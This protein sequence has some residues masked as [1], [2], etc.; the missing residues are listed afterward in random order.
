MNKSKNLSII[1]RDLVVDGNILSTGRL[2]I[3]GT[4]KGEIKGETV[5]IAEEGAVYCDAKVM[6]ITIGGTF[7]GEIEA[8]EELVILATGYCAGKVV[9]KDLVVESGGVLNADVTCKTVGQLKQSVDKKN[10]ISS[11]AIEL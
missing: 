11:K 5:V 3:K 4:V 7:E 2:V 1:D 10:K 9:C 8:S 6:G